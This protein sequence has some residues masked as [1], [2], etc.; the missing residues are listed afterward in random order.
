MKRGLIG[1]LSAVA[2]MAAGAVA[3]SVTAGTA[4][5]KKIEEMAE[6]QRKVHELYMAFD[7]WLRIRQEGKTLVEYFVKNGYKT[8]AIYG[9]KE[10][11]ERLHD[12][13]QGS[14]ITVKYAID[15]NAD[16]I[17]ADVDVLMPDEKMDLVDVIVVTALYYFDEIEEML[18]DKVDCPIISLEEILYEV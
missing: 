6:G 4:S 1:V 8:V 10:L 14:D 7:Q 12:E 2:G 5:S 18:S 3:G 9:M 17:Y 11:G 15:K 13:L 16:S